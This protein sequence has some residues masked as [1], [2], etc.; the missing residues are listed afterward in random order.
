MNKL[1]TTISQFQS[2]DD[3]FRL[4]LLLDY[5]VKLPPLPEK[6]QTAKDAG[7]NRVHECH[8]PVYLWVEVE[9]GKAKLFADVAAE[10]PT[11]R[12][13]VSILVNSLTG[14]EPA[15]IE[16]IPNDLLFR[17]G[18]GRQVGMVRIQGLSAILQR[19]KKEVRKQMKSDHPEL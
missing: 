3:E 19:I 17:L 5:A 9:K 14:A 7:L 18:I 15:E 10:A 12:G 1:E 2:L 4:D 8:T 16:N 13:L 11:V 6:Y